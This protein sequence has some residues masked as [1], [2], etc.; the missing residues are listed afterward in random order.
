MYLS[1][2]HKAP[3]DEHRHAGPTSHLEPF[4]IVLLDSA[5]KNKLKCISG[6]QFCFGLVANS[7]K[8]NYYN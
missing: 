4:V 6:F 2:I 3:I 1:C 8:A 5:L 7:P